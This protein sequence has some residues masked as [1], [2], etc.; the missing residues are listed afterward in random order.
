MWELF[1]DEKAF[2]QTNPI[3]VV[4]AIS[5]GKRPDI[6]KVKISEIKELIEESWA[7]DYKVR[8][9]FKEILQRLK[10]IYNIYKLNKLSKD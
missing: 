5:V 4:Y 6:A 1:S 8:P 7:D 3:S 9:S 2:E 10:N